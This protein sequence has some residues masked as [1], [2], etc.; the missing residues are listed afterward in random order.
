M[1]WPH[2]FRMTGDELTAVAHGLGAS[3]FPG[4]PAGCYD[5][6]G[7]DSHE[8]LDHAF[9]ASLLARGLLT[10]DDEQGLWP[11]DELAA[12][13]AV[14][15]T[16]RVRV[17][18]EQ[19]TPESTVVWQL[20]TGPGGT[21]RHLVGD[22]VHAFE[23]AAEGVLADVLGELVGRSPGSGQPGR[24]QRWGPLSTFD[25]IMVPPE[26][27]W[28]RSTLMV[29]TDETGDGARVEGLLGVFDGGPGRLWLV[30]EHDTGP[31]EELVVIAEPASADEVDQAVG[32]FA[33][34]VPALK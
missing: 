15:T 29:R 7:A 6:I 17:T 4:V 18:V 1:T 21:M 20:M 5:A 13:L 11:S 24:H 3:L 9:G 34:V 25:D 23:V 31:D 33:A 14:V 19:F 2:A 30:R 28:Q 10:V 8:L 26:G 22:P 27:G 12:L 16:H 32:A